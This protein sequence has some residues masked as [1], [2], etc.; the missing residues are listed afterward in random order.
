MLPL[1]LVVFLTVGLSHWFLVPLVHL[2]TPLFN[3][4][5]LGWV[6]LAALLWLFA[7]A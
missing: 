6:G 1:L 7:G 2:A 5:W 3:L 4:G